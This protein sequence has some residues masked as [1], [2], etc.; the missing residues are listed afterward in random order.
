MY[1][2]NLT[3]CSPLHILSYTYLG[4]K[5]YE[6]V[7]AG[8]QCTDHFHPLHRNIYELESSLGSGWHCRKISQI[9]LSGNWNEAIRI[10]EEILDK[11]DDVMLSDFFFFSKFQPSQSHCTSM[12]LRLRPTMA[13]NEVT[14]WNCLEL[15]NEVAMRQ[16][17]IANYNSICFLAKSYRAQG[18]ALKE[19]EL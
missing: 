17:H 19:R 13:Y 11:I 14:K 12:T 9:L 5:R 6:S 16:P 3:P 18:P 10:R 15:S 4:G 7:L 8:L 2:R 1:I